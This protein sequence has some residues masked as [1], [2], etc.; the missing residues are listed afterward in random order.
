MPELAKLPASVIHQP[1]V[2]AGSQLA[3]AGI[4]IGTTYPEPIV[5][6]SEA[7]KAA[8]AALATLKQS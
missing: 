6:H 8:L 7:R 5:D 2:V 1:E 4:T 3:T